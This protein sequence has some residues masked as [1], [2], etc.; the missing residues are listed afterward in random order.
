M[1]R[2]HVAGQNHRVTVHLDPEI[3]HVECA[4]ERSDA[5]HQSVDDGVAASELGEW[6]ADVANGAQVDGCT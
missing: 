2:Q 5:R 1:L 6:E 4:V 3:A